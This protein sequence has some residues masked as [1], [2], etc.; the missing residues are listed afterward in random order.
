MLRVF[1]VPSH[2]SYVSKLTSTRFTPVPPPF[3]VPLRIADLLAVA[4]WDFF[5]ILHL[6]TVERANSAELASLSER[7]KRTRK[8]LVFTAHD[9][10]PNIE[11]N[12]EAFE[13]RPGSPQPPDH[14]SSR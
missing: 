14:A 7:L 4:S 8:G 13:R 10:T 2:L 3:G 1:H 6:H 5:D 9:L 11:A 12:H